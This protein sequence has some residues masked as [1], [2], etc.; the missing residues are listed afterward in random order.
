MR[1]AIS[2]LCGG[3]RL[4][5]HTNWWFIPVSQK[6]LTTQ[7]LFACNEHLITSLVVSTAMLQNAIAVID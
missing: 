6:S 3:D 4:I 7:K 5:L 1:M 2:G